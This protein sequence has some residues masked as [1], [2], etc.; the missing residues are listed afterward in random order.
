MIIPRVDNVTSNRISITK[1]VIHNINA[2]IVSQRP[3][4]NNSIGLHYQTLYT[5]P[6]IY[7]YMYGK[8]CVLVTG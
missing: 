5:E 2:I 4:L 8:F 7:I 6:Y 3:W 1:A